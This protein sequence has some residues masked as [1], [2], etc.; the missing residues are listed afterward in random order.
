[1]RGV[2]VSQ[3]TLWQAFVL[4]FPAR[5]GG[6]DE[7]Q[8]FVVVLEALAERDVLLLPPRTGHR[9]ALRLGVLLPV[10][11]DRVVVPRVRDRA[12]RDSPWH[13]LLSWI[14][15]LPTATEEEL[16]FLRRVHDGLV[17]G[18]FAHAAPRKRRSLELCNDEKRLSGLMGGRLFGAGRLS[19]ELLGIAE[20]ALPLVWEEVGEAPAVLV[21]EN[22]DAFTF[23]LR[24]LRRCD[25]PPWGIVA[26]GDGDRVSRSLQWLR[27]VGRPIATIT[28]VGDL[29]WDGLG[30]AH[31]AREAARRAGLPDIEPATELHTMMLSAAA[32]LGRA[33]GWPHAGACD[34]SDCERLVRFLT[35]QHREAVTAIVLAK[36]RI[37]EEILAAEEWAEIL[38]GRDHSTVLE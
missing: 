36:R 33:D 20:D 14:A 29:D 13:P 18:A 22:A 5:P 19:V 27:E 15:D 30:A 38:V 1:M 4:A 24:R 26:F 16:A 9:W 2:R 12:W 28:Y 7:L 31:L 17:R 25:R 32:R 37:P 3:E 10:S 21:F 11:V 35:P 8:M 23:A 6:A 34:R